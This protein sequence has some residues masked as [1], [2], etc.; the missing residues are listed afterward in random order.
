MDATALP[1]WLQALLRRE[2]GGNWG[3]VNDGGYSGGF[4]FGEGAARDSGTYSGDDNLRD[5]RFGGTFTGPNGETL[6]YDQWLA[7]PEA[8]VATMGGWTQHLD[9][10]IR[11]RGLDR[12]V[13]Q[14]VDGV[15]VTMEGLY[16]GAHLGGIGGLSSWLRGSGNPADGNGTRV[17]DYV[18]MGSGSGGG[19]M[20][21]P[22]MAALAPAAGG[23]GMATGGL[24]GV[25]PPA[26][27][28]LRQNWLGGL[29]D[30]QPSEEQGLLGSIV[31][32]QNASD[33][34]AVMQ[35][36]AA[37]LQASG[38]STDPRGF[39]QSL[40]A[41]LQGYAAGQEFGAKQDERKIAQQTRMQV[42]AAIAALPPEQQAW[43]RANPAAFSELM[44]KQQIGGMEPIVTDGG[45]VLD[46]RGNVIADHRNAPA[47]PQ[48][49]A[50]LQEYAEAQRQGFTGTLLE[51]EQQ[52]A[53]AG[54]GPTGLNG[55]TGLDALTLQ[56]LV[57]NG[58]ITKA[59]ADDYALGRPLTI[60]NNTYLY[61]PST[62]FGTGPGVA[63]GVAPPGG[64]AAPPGASGG[65]SGPSPGSGTAPAGATPIFTAPFV[66]NEN[67]SK[68][69]TYADRMAT[70]APIIDQFEGSGLDVW[71]SVA[72]LAGPLASSFLTSDDYKR[73]ETAGNA[74]I[75]GVLRK[76]S[77]AV[78]TPDERASYWHQYLP[79]PNDPPELLAEKRQ[80]R[81]Q[82]IAS[83]IGDAGPGYAPPSVGAPAGGTAP[84]AAPAAPLPPPTGATL[85]AAPAAAAPGGPIQEWTIDPSTGLPTRV[86]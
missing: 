57:D 20:Q 16:T 80:R 75:S 35:M 85:N 31:N 27:P 17:G 10:Q 60:G 14:T 26:A 64:V 56:A 65:G 72:G 9:S 84:A 61:T 41:G 81:A 78:L 21:V 45:L 69:R 25:T 59:Q 77:G 3:I 23:Q 76:D 18:A 30:I 79:E 4:Q 73:F 82:A 5:N 54:R 33:R 15:P 38:P 62:I 74:W 46:H 42:E 53:A 58:T 43:A 39:G 66:P 19:G 36:A 68:A 11:G 52:K 29:L 86:K 28:A 51:Y 22:T 70:A 44:L 40:G 24:L 67:Q 48:P 37:M 55:G 49:T 71:N 8:Q 63:P 7:S 2:S 13:G 50:A 6:T 32:P 47:G 1:P 34:Q 12:Y 83:M